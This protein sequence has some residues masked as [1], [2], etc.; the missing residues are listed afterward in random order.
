[1][2]GA[3]EARF[4]GEEQEAEVTEGEERSHGHTI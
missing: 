2:I 1:M 3:E 4:E